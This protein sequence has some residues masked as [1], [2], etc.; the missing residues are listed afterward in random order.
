MTEI[1]KK[2]I[3]L[4]REN[5]DVADSALQERIDAECDRYLESVGA[6]ERFSK[7]EA[8]PSSESRLRRR[9]IVVSF[10]DDEYAQVL[11]A[12]GGRGPVAAGIRD[13]AL[14]GA[15]ATLD[16]LRK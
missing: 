5:Y 6:S 11:A 16:A 7:K 13:M 15:A 10:N 9:R 1:D 3:G 8:A 12:I 2:V 4:L 14:A